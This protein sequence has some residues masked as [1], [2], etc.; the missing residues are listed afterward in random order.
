MSFLL[1][2]PHFCLTLHSVSANI[3]LT[4]KLEGK[5][6]D[7]GLSMLTENEDDPQ[8][9]FCVSTAA[10]TRSYMPPEAFK[11]KVSPRVDIYSFGMVGVVENETWLLLEL[12]I[13]RWSMRL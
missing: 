5:L 11:G 12:F 6:A 2:F 3:L 9:S 4:D 10:G 7:F 1:K 8:A 13:C